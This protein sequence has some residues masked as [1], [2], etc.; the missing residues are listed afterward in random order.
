[1]ATTETSTAI[2]EKLKVKIKKPSMFKVVFNNDDKTPMDFVIEVLMVIF[3]HDRKTAEA[4][5]EEVHVKGKGIAGVYSY[6]VAEQK[7]VE[8]TAAARQNSFPLTVNVE[9][10]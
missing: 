8:T 5:T 1:M 4:I 2:R 7:M 10:E 6:E 9:P 3:H